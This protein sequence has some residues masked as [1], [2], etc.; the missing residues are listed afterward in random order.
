MQLVSSISDENQRNAMVQNLAR[1]WMRN[2][3]P[4]ATQ[5]VNNSSLPDQIKKNILQQR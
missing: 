4:A 5:W 1:N 2:D 3:S